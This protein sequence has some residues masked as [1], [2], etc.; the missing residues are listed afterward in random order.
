MRKFLLKLCK[1]DISNYFSFFLLKICW[2]Q[3]KKNGIKEAIEDKQRCHIS[4]ILNT[5]LGK[6]KKQG[7]FTKKKKKKKK[8]D[9][10][11]Q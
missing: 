1:T 9:G 8:D 11:S 4:S 7:Y 2:K 6:K 5:K 10:F 3:N